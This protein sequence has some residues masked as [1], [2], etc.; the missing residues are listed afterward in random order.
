[1]EFKVKSFSELNS[2]EMYQLLQLRSDVFVIEQH[3]IYKDMDD[4]DQSCYHLIGVEGG[5]VVA[6]SRLVPPG[7]SYE[8][9]SIGRVCTAKSVRMEGYGMVLMEEAIKHCRLL[10][11]ISCITISAQAYLEKFY[12]KF[13][14]LTVSEPYLEDDIPHVKMILE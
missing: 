10:W 9:A 5:N 3:C 11:P 13:G 6:Y 2:L 14:F 12:M 1:M 4:K 7:I 8:N